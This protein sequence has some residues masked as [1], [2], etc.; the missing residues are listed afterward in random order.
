MSDGAIGRIEIN[1]APAQIADLR[2][3]AATNYGHFTSMQVH[4]GCVRGLDL[5]L[6]R[7][8]QATRTL[9]GSS[10]DCAL[11]RAWMRQAVGA[12]P[13][14]L[15]LRVNVFSRG[16]DREHPAAAVQAEV[17]VAIG[18]PAQAA[19]TPLRVKS[20]AYERTLPEV[21]HVGT[22][23]LFQHRRMAQLA[24]FDDA[25]FVDRAGCVSEGSVWNVGFV[26]GDEIVW[27]KAQQL[28]GVAMQLLQ[29]GI[30]RLGMRSSVRPVMLAE[31]GRFRHAF[32]TNSS[33]PVRPIASIDAAEFAE[34]RELDA[35][36]VACYESSPRIRI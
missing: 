20:F 18:A 9:F 4:D 10:L 2:F 13:Q 17:L 11:V 6:D 23:P 33:Q 26:D 3:L 1:G 25:L 28:R 8:E 16:F 32:F 19:S 30:E 24:G 34:D 12:D 7:L 5:H 36:F 31:L 22:F 15:S 29:A 27:S 35:R 14:P 21:K